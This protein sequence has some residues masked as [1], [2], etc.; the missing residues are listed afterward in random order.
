MDCARK[1]SDEDETRAFVAAQFTS[2][3][4][5]TSRD[6]SQSR[7]TPSVD[8]SSLLCIQHVRF[9]G[10]ICILCLQRSLASVGFRALSG[11]CP[12]VTKRL[13]WVSSRV[14]LFAAL[15]VLIAH[16][17]TQYVK[18]YI[19]ALIPSPF[20]W[21][22]ICNL[23]QMSCSQLC[24]QSVKALLGINLTNLVEISTEC[25]MIRVAIS[26]HE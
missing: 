8:R 19:N 9:I 7:I 10:R 4:F 13:P 20:T 21:Q 12:S 23:F 17:T 11:I 3:S 16:T 6:F 1:Q 18:P 15:I 24:T 5:V 14:P 22:Q 26:I 25:M 2:L